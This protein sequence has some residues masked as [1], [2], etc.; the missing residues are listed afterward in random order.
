MDI[1]SGVTLGWLL[2]PWAGCPRRLINP[3]GPHHLWQARPIPVQILIEEENQVK[4]L[5]VD[6][7]R[8]LIS[9][10]GIVYKLQRY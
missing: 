10:F 2:R 5:V 3:R 8:L 7:N 6:L 4:P 1:V 9:D